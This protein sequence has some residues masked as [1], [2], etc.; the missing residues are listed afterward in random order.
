M[1]DKGQLEQIL[2]NLAINAQD[3]IS[4]DGKLTIETDIFERTRLAEA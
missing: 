2:M 1:A 4:N 3:A